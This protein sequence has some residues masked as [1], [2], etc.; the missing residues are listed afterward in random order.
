MHHS[1]VESRSPTLLSRIGM[2]GI[3]LD[4]SVEK[5][6]VSLGALQISL[7]SKNEFLA[8]SYKPTDLAYVLY[9]E[10]DL[11]TLHWLFGELPVKALQV[12]LQIA[13][14]SMLKSSTSDWL[15]RMKIYCTMSQKTATT[16]G[17]MK[18]TV[19]NMQQYPTILHRQIRYSPMDILYFLV[20][21]ETHL[22][23]ATSFE[24]R[25]L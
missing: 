9:I 10:Q 25:K 23:A 21:K 19:E 11:Q 22:C 14:S 16:P 15:E 18:Q 1:W 17:K 13:A 12:L 8:H 3:G 6:N 2:V 4:I 24:S 7:L 5:A 20:N